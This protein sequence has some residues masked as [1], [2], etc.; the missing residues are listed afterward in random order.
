[1]SK[2]GENILGIH[3]DFLEQKRN[4]LICRTNNFSS[5]IDYKNRAKQEKESI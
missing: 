5:K 2:G 4:R 1:M 3:F